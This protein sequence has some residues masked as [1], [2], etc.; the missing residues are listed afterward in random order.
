MQCERKLVSTIGAFAVGVLALAAPPSLAQDTAGFEQQLTLTLNSEARYMAYRTRIATPSNTTHQGYQFYLPFG[1]QAEA[2]LGDAAKLDFTVRSGWVRTHNK[3][4]F[5]TGVTQ[6]S[7]IDTWTDTSIST[8]ANFNAIAGIQPFVQLSVNLPT[9]RANL[10]QNSRAR[11]DS[12]TVELPTYGE[13]VNWAPTVGVNIPISQAAMISLGLG[14]TNRGAFDREAATVGLA[15]QPQ[16]AR[17]D[18]GNVTTYNI[19]LG[20]QQGPFAFQGSAAYSTETETTFDDQPFYKS[21]DRY[22]LSGAVGYSWNQYWASRINTSFSHFGKNNI[23]DTVP[24]NLLITEALNSNSNVYKVNIDSS[25]TE[26]AWSIG[27]TL[28]YVYRDQNA[29]SPTEQ[30]FLPAKTSWSLG[31]VTQWNVTGKASVNARVERLWITEDDNPNKIIGGPPPIPGS[32]T[33]EQ[34]TDVWVFSLGGTIKF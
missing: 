8:T 3:T 29:W 27:P 33:P 12:D 11:V 10:G 1:T 32:G 14:Y 9:G 5:G 19:G 31:G 21:G 18:P 24:P 26:G 13:G 25:Y 17:L 4:T 20:Y 15:G 16:I 30:R 22:M 23:R 28:G 2:R 34:K 6:T 7:D